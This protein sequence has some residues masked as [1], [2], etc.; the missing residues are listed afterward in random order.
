MKPKVAVGFD[1]FAAPKTP[2]RFSPP[3]IAVGLA[4]AVLILT[5]TDRGA[6]PSPGARP[7]V[8]AVQQIAPGGPLIDPVHDTSVFPKLEG[9]AS[10]ERSATLASFNRRLGRVE[11]GS[12]KKSGAL[13][14]PSAKRRMTRIA[15]DGRSTHFQGPSP[16]RESWSR[17][18]WS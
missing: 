10:G 16:C 3:V 7:P 12:I 1:E 4:L 11:D 6:R 8:A 13:S 5:R 17:A 14:N 15:V 2:R 9:G 18:I